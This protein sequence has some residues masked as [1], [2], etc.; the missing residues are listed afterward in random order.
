[1]LGIRCAKNVLCHSIVRIFKMV[2][3]AL[4]EMDVKIFHINKG[5]MPSIRRK[6]IQWSCCYV[7]IYLA[8]YKAWVCL[9][10]C[11]NC[12]F[13]SRWGHGCLSLVS[14]V[15]FQVEVSASD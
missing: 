5:N 15:C 10:A 13:E 2:L 7:T 9:L 3:S 4:F 8:R 12:G 1:M 6:K 11:W 14:V